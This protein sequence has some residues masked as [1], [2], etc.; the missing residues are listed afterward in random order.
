MCLP[1]SF[2]IGVS[3]FPFGSSIGHCGFSHFSD[4]SVFLNFCL[5]ILGNAVVVLDQES[6]PSYVRSV[7]PLMPFARGINAL[8][9]SLDL[10]KVCFPSKNYFAKFSL[11]QVHP[12]ETSY[13]VANP[14]FENSFNTS[15]SH[16]SRIIQTSMEDFT[17]LMKNVKGSDVIT[18]VA[19]SYQV[20]TSNSLR[21]TGSSPVPTSLSTTL[22][23]SP[24]PC[25]ELTPL[26]LF[27]NI[28]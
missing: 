7:S 19:P 8:G 12:T 17:S 26:K 6:H 4:C 28:F 10:L 5:I 15:R 16:S 27:N 22:T 13:S 20:L 2:F 1:F 21:T 23:P 11:F 24:S 3:T 18:P 14:L 9:Q 25:S